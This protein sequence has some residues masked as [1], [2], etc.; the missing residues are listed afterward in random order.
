MAPVGSFAC[1]NLEYVPVAQLDRASV[2]EAEGRA[3]DPRQAQGFS[4]LGIYWYA[5]VFRPAYF[6]K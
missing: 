4:G 1:H 3:F 6:Q 2:S 5:M